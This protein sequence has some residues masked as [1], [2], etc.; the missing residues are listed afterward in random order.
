VVLG[1]ILAAGLVGFGAA[2]WF[3]VGI[4]LIQLSELSKM[5]MVI[6]VADYLAHHQHE[7]GQF[8]AFLR[9]LVLT[10]IPVG[11]VF[12]QPDLSRH[13]PGRDLGGAGVRSGARLRHF[14]CCW[15]SPGLCSCCSRSFGQLLHH[16]LPG[17]ARTSCSFQRYQMQRIVSFILPDPEAHFGESYNVNQALI[18]IGS[19]GWFG[20][21]YGHGT[22]T[23][24]GSQGTP[25]R[26]HLLCAPRR[27][28]ASSAPS[29][30]W[31]C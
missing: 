26:L 1:L 9:S 4:V 10:G 22:Q 28:S 29:P 15:P 7:I 25:H 2:R 6:V 14:L 16:G 12:L 23:Q 20:Q 18:S 5:L 11:M 17:R 21:G 30:C 8:R 24:P 13:R 27:S 19:G 3:D 31:P